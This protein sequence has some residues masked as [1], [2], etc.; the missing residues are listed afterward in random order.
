MS[1]NN[2]ACTTAPTLLFACSGGA[3]VGALADK[4]GRKATTRGHA[5]MFCLA[6]VGG[7]VEPILKACEAA[8]RLVAVDGCP[9]DCAKKSLEAAGLP[10]AVHLRLTDMGMEKGKCAMTDNEVDT[11]VRNIADALT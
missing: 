10:V 8:S 5:K 1:K 7:R 3:D 9:M 6:G 11:I 4:A 2:C